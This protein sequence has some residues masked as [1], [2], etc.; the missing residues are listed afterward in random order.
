MAPNSY[1]GDILFRRYCRIYNKDHR[2][3]EEILVNYQTTGAY[4]CRSYTRAQASK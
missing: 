1:I 3:P 4:G 2:S